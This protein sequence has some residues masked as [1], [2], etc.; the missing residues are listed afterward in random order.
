[1]AAVLAL[2]IERPSYGYEL[3]KRYEDR[4]GGL[5]PVTTPRVY[6]CLG[7]LEA[8]GLVEEI[9]A[10]PEAI[11]RRQ[12]KPHYRATSQGLFEHRAWMAATFRD[13]PLREELLRR[14]LATSARDAAAL[15]EIINVYEQACLA[16]MA[17]ARPSGSGLSPGQGS[18]DAHLRDQLIAEEARLAQ[19]SRLKFVAFARRLIQSK[20]DGAP[21]VG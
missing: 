10:K 3:W 11:Q 15:L 14:F 6:Q 20:I 7:Q 18:A 4:F 1:M 12:P 19:E 13:D 9:P 5:Y 16:E 8:R 17:S 2:V 21:Q